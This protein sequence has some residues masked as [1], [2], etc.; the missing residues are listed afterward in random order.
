MVT[1]NQS[2]LRK[3]T[4][5]MILFLEYCNASDT[6]SFISDIQIKKEEF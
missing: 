5:V 1:V 6:K 4:A 2:L 3:L